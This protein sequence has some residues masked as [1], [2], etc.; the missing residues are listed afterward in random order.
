MTY[1]KKSKSCAL[2]LEIAKT[3]GIEFQCT[4]QTTKHLQYCMDSMF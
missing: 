2:Y 4:K 1:G 3:M